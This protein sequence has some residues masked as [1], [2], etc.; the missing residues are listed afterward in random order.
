MKDWKYYNHA[1]IPNCA[2]HECP[3]IT[4]IKNGKIWKIGGVPLFARWTTDF[5]CGEETDFWYVIKDTPFDINSLKS[6][7]RYKITKGNRYFK[8][9]RL[10]RPSDYLDELYDV[11]VAAFSAY[12]EKY[13]P[14]VDYDKFAKAVFSWER[15]GAMVYA[16][17][18]R[19]SGR[20]CGYSQL[21]ICDNVIHLNVL[22]ACPESEKFQI[23]AAIVNG[24]LCENSE[25]L[26]CGMYI[27]DGARNVYHETLFQDYLE[28]YFGFRKAYCKLH[29]KLN[30]LFKPMIMVLYCFRKIF[31]RLDDFGFVHK[32][33]GVFS[34]ME[35]ADKNEF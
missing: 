16:A 18:S 7:R 31:F 1:V 22:K 28:K 3:D 32:M 14:T 20:I 15:E 25:K 33:N 27:C 12:P 11:Q 29:I 6:N 19:E 23:N 17:I 2:P 30:P 10:V 35:M 21:T 13:R 9:I 26:K 4:L 24:I 5:D 34:M 8:V